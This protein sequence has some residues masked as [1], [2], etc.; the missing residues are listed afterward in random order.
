M[1]LQE[2]ARYPEEELKN[3][4]EVVADAE[5]DIV[6]IEHPG[7]D[8]QLSVGRL[9]TPEW[10]DIP[11]TPQS[12][13]PVSVALKPEHNPD[14]GEDFIPATTYGGEIQGYVFRNGQMG[15]GYYRKAA[16]LSTQGQQESFIPKQYDGLRLGYVYMKNDV[17]G[18]GYY[19]MSGQ[20]PRGAAPSEFLSSKSFKGTKAGFIF[21]QGNQGLG[22][23]KTSVP[24][25][26]G[27]DEQ[28]EA[29]FIN[30]DPIRKGAKVKRGTHWNWRVNGDED[31]GA[32]RLG[33]VLSV[34]E[35]EKGIPI[36]GA[37]SVMWGSTGTRS[38]Y[39]MGY[40]DKFELA[41]CDEQVIGVSE[42]MDPPLPV[43]SFDAHSAYE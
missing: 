21:R 38:T 39:L 23:Y 4:A 13:K 10:P 7:F 25:P 34:N 2:T 40:Q 26:M 32:G 22:Y 43:I 20:T 18:A 33:T 31:G 36:P 29:T 12:P 16:L 14:E 27:Q 9:G 11:G 1:V 28:V 19:R 24:I 15:L 8:N 42:E 5:G 6:Y 37:V 17:F 41:S 35:N 30:G 3:H